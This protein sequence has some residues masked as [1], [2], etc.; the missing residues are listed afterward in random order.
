M[1]NA[2]I[3]TRPEGSVELQATM[4]GSWN[5]ALFIAQAAAISGHRITIEDGKHKMLRG[6]PLQ[7]IKVN[8]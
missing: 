3:D 8:V 4:Y 5:K 2:K 1:S 7:T 6:L